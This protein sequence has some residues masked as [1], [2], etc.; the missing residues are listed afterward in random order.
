MEGPISSLALFESVTISKY[1]TVK[2]KSLN[3]YVSSFVVDM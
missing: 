1:L 3:V 2:S